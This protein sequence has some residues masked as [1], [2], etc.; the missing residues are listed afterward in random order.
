MSL[1][2]DQDLTVQGLIISLS[3]NALRSK[4]TK[5][6]QDSNKKEGLSPLFYWN[7]MS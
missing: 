5:F 6:P 2:I 7:L 4:H 3:Y 1:R